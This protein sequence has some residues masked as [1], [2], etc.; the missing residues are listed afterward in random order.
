MTDA[1]DTFE[2]SNAQNNVI[3][4]IIA[5]IRDELETKRATWERLALIGRIVLA[6]IGVGGGAMAAK[7]Y[8]ETG[9]FGPDAIPF[10]IAAL[11]GLVGAVLIR[12]ANAGAAGSSG[13]LFFSTGT[14]TTAEAG[15]PLMT[16]SIPDRATGVPRSGWGSAGGRDSDQPRTS[17]RR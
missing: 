9:T 10:G 2:G 14:A 1:P 12:S 7:I 13:A 8:F 5:P 4:D 17:A 15:Q 16:R 11:I 6:L 3:N